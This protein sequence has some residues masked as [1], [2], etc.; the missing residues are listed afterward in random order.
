MNK[1]R[2]LSLKDVKGIVD[3]KDASKIK[4]L[5]RSLSKSLDSKEVKKALKRMSVSGNDS[6]IKLLAENRNTKTYPFKREAYVY[7]L[8]N[9]T[10]ELRIIAFLEGSKF[11]DEREFKNCFKKVH[12]A[13]ER[14]KILKDNKYAYLYPDEFV[15][16]W[17]NSNKRTHYKM[18]YNLPSLHF[19]KKDTY[20]NRMTWVD[21]SRAYSLSKIDSK[22]VNVIE[23]TILDFPVNAK[24]AYAAALWANP[25]LLNKIKEDTHPHIKTA[26]AN[27]YLFNK[28][29][30]NE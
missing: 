30:I 14:L 6:E 16:N 22:I 5:I 25:E 19:A 10:G 17:N 13:A 4:L 8:E 26:L 11:L 3:S 20:E 28:G 18:I 23:S 1:N 2:D 12:D 27:N 9:L 21:E 15:T 29:A 24:V 7:L